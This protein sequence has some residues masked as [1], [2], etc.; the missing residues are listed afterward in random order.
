M[1]REARETDDM[2]FRE[3]RQ[4]IMSPRNSHFWG[5]QIYL[6]SE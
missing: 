3:F 6:Q 2:K 1:T 4:E 5:H